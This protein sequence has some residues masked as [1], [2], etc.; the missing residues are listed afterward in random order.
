MLHVGVHSHLFRGS[1]AIVAREARRRGLTCL[2][3]TPDFP[4][5]SFIEP[6]QITGDRCR[7]AAAPFLEIGLAVAAVS[8]YVNLLDDDLTRRHVGIVRW[9]RLIEHC[10]DFGTPYLVLE[11]GWGQCDGDSDSQSEESSR[12][13]LCFILEAGLRVADDHATQILI[14]PGGATLLATL[15]Q[16]LQ[17]KAEPGLETLKYVLDPATMLMACQPNDVPSALQRLCSALGHCAPLVHAKDLRLDGQATSQPPVGQGI[18]NYFDFI[19]EYQSFQA[20]GPIILEHVRPDQA[21]AA[22]DYIKACARPGN[23]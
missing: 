19:R 20:R 11:A 23:A 7:R 13:E 6:G 5:L 15:E 2:Q 17:M 21:E 22:A 14:N 18:I 10:R 4:G 12:R 16:L 8:C 3:L 9:H 1:A